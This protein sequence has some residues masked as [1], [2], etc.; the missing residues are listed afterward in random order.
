MAVRHRDGERGTLLAPGALRADG[1]AVQLHQ[2]AD[3]GEPQPETAVLARRAPVGLAEALEHVRQELPRDADARV[4]HRHLHVG[5]VPREA[6]PHATAGGSELDAVHEQVPHHLLDAR[7]VAVDG[8]SLGIDDGL[9]PDLLGVG[10]GS[11]GVDRR[12]D[13]GHQAEGLYL[14]A[15]VRFIIPYFWHTS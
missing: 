6:K 4:A 13:D 1:A 10:C 9:Q 3:D 2:M 15:A 7:R 5:T 12:L 8:S 14:E 11:H